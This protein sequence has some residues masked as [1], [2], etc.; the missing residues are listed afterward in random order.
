MKKFLIAIIA[1]SC[2]ASCD[3]GDIIVT[4]FDFEEQTLEQCT[5]FESQFV[6]F[7]IN[8]DNNES[9][10]LSFSTTQDIFGA[11]DGENARRETPIPLSTGDNVIYRRFDSSVT[12]DYF[13]NAI[14]PA[15]PI[16]VEEFISADGDITVITD[17]TYADSDGIPSDIEDP[18]GEVDT[19]GDGIPNILDFDDDGDNV[20]T[21]QEGVVITDGAI[22]EE[23]TRDTDG[24]GTF[25]YL[26]NDDDN[27]GVLTI[28]EDPN[29]DL[30]PSN[31]N[32]D[33][34][35]ESLDDYL[36]PAVTGTVNTELFREHVYFLNDIEIII[37]TQNLD[38]RNQNGEEV[39]RDIRS[40]L[41]G[42]LTGVPDAEFTTTPT[43]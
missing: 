30:D 41:F 31:D 10:A 25:D 16:V 35:N 36:N 18:T 29:M 22:N 21:A 32:S 33:P 24:D 15:T 26:D 27:D 34:D 7:K 39:I 19:D 14:P 1:I 23:L 42:V 11:G 17:G 37:N 20:P 28:N 43:F 38:F 4:S 40:L 9:I 12:S 13:C 5:N 3:D 6:F 2:L 8:P